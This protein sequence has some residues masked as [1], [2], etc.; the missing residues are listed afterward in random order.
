MIENAVKK[1]KIINCLIKEERPLILNHI[2]KKTDLDIQLVEYHIKKLIEEGIII[3]E[4]E[5]EKRY[6]RLSS[7]FYDV[8][9]INA[10]YSLLT[11]YVEA[12]AKELLE[13]NSKTTSDD[14]LITFM[15]LLLLFIDNVNIEIVGENVF[16]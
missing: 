8:D 11:P 13:G 9:N 15:Y 3:Y 7:P 4:N 16:Q 6:Y 10:L 2:A 5:E 1:L 14:V 12:T